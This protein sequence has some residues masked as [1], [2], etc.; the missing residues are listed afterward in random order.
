MPCELAK[1]MPVYNADGS[2]TERVSYAIS[3]NTVYYISVTGS[4]V[5]DFVIN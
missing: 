5:M 2:V 3:A 1:S 4:N